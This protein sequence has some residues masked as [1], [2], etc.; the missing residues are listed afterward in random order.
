MKYRLTVK[1]VKLQMG[2]GFQFFPQ[3]TGNSAETLK[4]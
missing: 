1:V 3:V 4:S 2:P